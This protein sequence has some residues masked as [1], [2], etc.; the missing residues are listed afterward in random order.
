M[1]AAILVYR[2]AGDSP[3]AE[4]RL[5]S[6]EHIR[7]KIDAAGV[8]VTD[9]DAADAGRILFQGDVEAVARLAVAMLEPGGRA[10]EPLD[11]LLGLLAPMP[12]VQA[13][14]TAFETAVVAPPPTAIS[15]PV[16]MVESATDPFHGKARAIALLIVCEML[17]M[18]VWFAAAAALPALR[19]SQQ[20]G[21]PLL[22]ALL[23]SSVQAGF[24]VGTLASA[25]LSLPDR[26]DPRR[27]F[28][29]S[30]A[31]AG[32]VSIACVSLPPGSGFLVPLRLLAG[33]C[34]AGVYPVGLK[35]A[36]TWARGDAGLL[37][38]L[39]VG[40]LTIGSA[41][42]HLVAWAE[43]LDWRGIYIV[44]GLLS[45]L[46]AWGTRYCSLGPNRSKAPPFDPRQVLHAWSIRPLRLANLGYLGHMW[47]LYAMWAWIGVF[48]RASFGKALG[49]HPA[50]FWAPVA[51]FATIA[52]G[53]VGCLAGGILADR[54]GRTA[55]TSAAMLVSGLCALTVGLTFA[56]PPVLVLAVCL[57]WGVSI[58]ADSAQFSASVSELSDRS[59]VG[60]MLTIQT[61][62]GFL[63]TLISIHLLPYAVDW[64]GWRWAFA[65]LAIGPFLGVIAM[66]RL[67]GDPAAVKLAGGRR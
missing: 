3:N 41:S 31:T 25:L 55:V 12:S 47:E 60:T 21:G 59:L 53:A 42:P 34:L 58:V 36:S 40:A 8:T 64:L 46:A 14:R 56:G 15:L 35:I 39:L 49:F 66:L 11:L 2:N 51:T 27:L 48:L 65:I 5:Q 7:I 17:A 52:V 6:G 30:A 4:L 33:I 26:Y 10:A 38:G 32:L 23:T 43:G 16:A 19:K 28:G 18:G 54:V 37:M 29:W 61:T 45:L 9:V 44:A 22:E 67:R 20:S 24:V 1:L 13:I 62:Q 63:L 50:E 57:I